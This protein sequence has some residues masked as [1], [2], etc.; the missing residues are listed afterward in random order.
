MDT[1]W[2]TN[3]AYLFKKITETDKFSVAIAIVKKY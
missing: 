1:V 2:K 3:P